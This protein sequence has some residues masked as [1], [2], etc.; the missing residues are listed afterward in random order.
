MR[1]LASADVGV[2]V[3]VGET[4]HAAAVL[5]HARDG[6]ATHAIRQILGFAQSTGDIAQLH[7]A[8]GRRGAVIVAGAFHALTAADAVTLL[9]WAGDR[10]P[11]LALRI[12]GAAGVSAAGLGSGHAHV[13][14]AV[15]RVAQVGGASLDEG[16]SGAV[17]SALA[18][19]V[20]VASK[21][22]C[23]TLF[24]GALTSF[25]VA[26]G[27][28]VAL[29]DQLKLLTVRGTALERAARAAILLL[30]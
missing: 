14:L 10:L 16:K 4:L 23:T 17:V 19:V 1:Q 7:A 3:F 25:C 22:A 6:H 27:G 24:G 5:A 11:R 15:G 30:R 26:G 12:T 13:A 21:L 28:G 2:A 9:S 8:C 18:Q 29:F 20:A